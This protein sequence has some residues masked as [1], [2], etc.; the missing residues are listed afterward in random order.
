MLGELDC[1]EVVKRSKDARVGIDEPLHNFQV[2]IIGGVH[3]SLGGLRFRLCLGLHTHH[4]EQDCDGTKGHRKE[5]RHNMFVFHSVHALPGRCWN[6]T[7]DCRRPAR[8]LT[9][10]GAGPPQTPSSLANAHREPVLV[11][12]QL[13]SR[14]GARVSPMKRDCKHVRDPSPTGRILALIT[15]RSDLPSWLLWADKPGIGANSHQSIRPLERRPSSSIKTTRTGRLELQRHIT[16]LCSSA[17]LPG[18]KLRTRR[19][20]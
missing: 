6:H 11:R 19:P 17:L 1:A 9:P 8:T 18:A 12:P 20:T 2:S 7:P 16:R 14:A 4:Q 13:G 10:G 3:G 15:H 5:N